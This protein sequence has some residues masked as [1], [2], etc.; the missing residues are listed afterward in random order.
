MD[1]SK[2]NLK[3]GSQGTQV[4]QFQTNL[5]AL[6]YYDGK[7]DGDF[8]SYTETCVKNFQ[9][10]FGL[11]TDGWI[12]SVTCQKIQ[13]L[14]SNSN[15]ENYV[16]NGVYHS[17]P[18]WVG[19]GCNK[20]G[21][22]TGYYCAVHCFRQCNSKMNIDSFYEK[23]LAGWAGTTT[24]GTSHYGIETAVAKVSKSIGRKINVQWKNFSDMGDSVNARFKAIGELIIKPNVDVI[25][26]VLYRNRYGHYETIKS[27]NT[28]NRTIVVLNSLGSKCSSPAYCGYLETRSYDTMASYLRGIS[29]KSICILTYE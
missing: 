8:G 18:H 26:H 19:K 6:G 20:L 14:L 7:L 5:K 17:G 22:C 27:I 4:I 21:Q 24:A 9:K 2:V 10:K 11:A 23:T 28:N 13:S 3:K 1:C 15:K 12:G 16:Q 29:Q 25:F